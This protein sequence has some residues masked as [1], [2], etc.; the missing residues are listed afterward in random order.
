[1]LSSAKSVI[2]FEEFVS[3]VH[4]FL[5]S[6]AQ[7]ARERNNYKYSAESLGEYKNKL[8]E[9]ILNLRKL[10]NNLIVDNTRLTYKLGNA[11]RKLVKD[12]LKKK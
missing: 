11:H 8:Q 2:V 3:G 6:V 1:M 12:S 4:T 9:D 10:N 5:M 7:T